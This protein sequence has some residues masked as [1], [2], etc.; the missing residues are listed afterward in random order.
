MGWLVKK[1]PE[2]DTSDVLA[3]FSGLVY[4]PDFRAAFND[5][6]PRAYDTSDGEIKASPLTLTSA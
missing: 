6:T 2:R 5:Q 4:H 3:G 1:Y